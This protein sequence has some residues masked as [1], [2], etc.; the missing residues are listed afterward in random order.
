MTLSSDNNIDN[1][2]DSPIQTFQYDLR[3]EIGVKDVSETIP[4]VT[5]FRDLIRRMISVA[6]ENHLEAMTATGRPYSA[7]NEMP[8]NEFQKEFKVDKVEGKTSKVLLGFKIHTLTKLADLKTRLIHTYLRPRNLFLREHAGGF[9]NGVKTYAYGYLKYDHPDHKDLTALNQRFARRVAEAWRNMDK[10]ERNKWKNELP[11]ILYGATGIMLPLT[12]TKER[13]AA[14]MD[15]RDKI[16][17]FAIVVST[18]SKYGKFA[19][20]VLDATLLTKKINNLIPFALNRENQSGFYYI[21]TEHANFMEN[22][23]NIPISQVPL[24]ATT[25]VGSEGQNLKALLNAHP[26]IQRVAYDA[27][28]RK[29]HV[30]TTA[31]KYMEV[32]QWIDGMLRENKFPYGPSLRPL[33]YNNTSVYGSIFKDAMSVATENYTTTTPSTPN[34]WRNRPPLDIS[35]IAS[36]EVFPPLPAKKQSATA[37]TVSETL[38][39][40]TIQSA[41]LAAIKKL[42]DQYKTELEKLKHEFQ[43]KMDSVQNQMAEIGEQGATQTYLALVKEDSPLATKHD[44][45]VLRQDV[46]LIKTQLAAIIQWF[47]AGNQVP[48][49]PGLLPQPTTTT[50]VHTPPSSQKT[51][52]KRSKVYTTPEKMRPLDFSKSQDQSVSSAASTYEGMEGCED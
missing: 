16:Q 36:E 21:T 5:I 33:K 50:V 46:S 23:R 22:H 30:S 35:Y 32:Y 2:K 41:I 31:N 14:S 11:E 25:I 28:Q 6:D 4:V 17:T 45:E 39:E 40:D 3:L 24:D 8:S 13:I 44:T 18:P 51:D 20:L 34:A 7:N 27:V 42:E 47:Q 38:E 9:E 48:G 49:P 52:P 10:E 15:G 43:K 37:S 26:H 29:C 19:K 12:F 1:L